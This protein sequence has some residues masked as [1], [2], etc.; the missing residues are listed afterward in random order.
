MRIRAVAVVIACIF[1]LPLTAVGQTAAGGQRAAAGSADARLNKL[2]PALR[3]KGRALLDERDEK[4]RADLAEELAEAD[5]AAA[6]DFLLDVLESDPAAGVRETIID[7]LSGLTHPGFRQALERRVVA[8]AEAKVALLALDTLRVQALA[9]LRR[10]LDQRLE[11]ARGRGDERQVRLLAREQERWLSLVKGALLPTFMQTPPPLFALKDAGQPVRVLAFG[12][13]GDG[14]LAQQQVAAA[15]LQYHRKQPFD[16]AVTL[17]DNFYPD[18]LTTLDDPRWKTQWE[19]LYG[20]LGVKFYATLGNHDW[21][22]PDGPAAEVLYARQS[23][24]WRMPATYYTFTA[25]PVQFFALDTNEISEAQLLWLNEELGKSRA[26]WKLVYGHHPIYSAG[27]HED[28][29]DKIRQLLPVLKGRADVYLAGHDHDMQH[30]K[31]EGSLHFFVAGSGGKLRPIEPGP[32]SLFARSANG[33]AVVEA[34][35]GQLKVKFIDAGLNQLYEYA[36]TKQ[37]Q[38]A[39]AGDR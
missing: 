9:P 21:H 32:R 33:F 4:K 31:P 37:G 34:D 36:L 1:F 23:P 2:P 25:G 13:F 6:L 14:S 16:F 20:P 39:P 22:L 38:A 11:A 18:G 27:R 28:N 7:E 26:R 12:D 24:S 15:T 35:A 5:A 29:D 19:D 10:L 17:G 30:L 8:D 3:D